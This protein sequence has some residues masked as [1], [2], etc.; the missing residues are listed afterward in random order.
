ML[1]MLAKKQDA[2]GDAM[3]CVWIYVLWLVGVSAVSN[4]ASGDTGS[5]NDNVAKLPPQCAQYSVYHVCRLFG[6][7][8]TL[9]DVAGEMPPKAG[10][11]S[12]L[13]MKRCL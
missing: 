7:P 11:E 3:M 5:V 10:G 13:E 6:I 8:V 9:E 2:K 12:M 1:G 4:Q